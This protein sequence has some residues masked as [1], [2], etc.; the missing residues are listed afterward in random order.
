MTNAE[1]VAEALKDLGPGWHTSRAVMWQVRRNGWQ[2]T[3][4]KTRNVCRFLHRQGGVGMLVNG[5]RYLF[6]T[7]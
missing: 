1:I 3:T 6:Q 4:A 2:I 7:R 5:C